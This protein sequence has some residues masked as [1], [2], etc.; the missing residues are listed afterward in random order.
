MKNLFPSGN[1]IKT[2][3]TSATLLYRLQLMVCQLLPLKMVVLL[4]YIG[5]AN[6]LVL[7]NWLGGL[8]YNRVVLGEVLPL[9]AKLRGVCFVGT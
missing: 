3:L 8:K 2:N 7:L 6:S 5:Y 1:P 9:F 4:T